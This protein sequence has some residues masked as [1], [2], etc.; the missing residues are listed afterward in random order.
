MWIGGF[1]GIPPFQSWRA[2]WASLD[3]DGMFAVYTN[4]TSRRPRVNFFVNC[5]E[6]AEGRDDKN[7]S[8]ND[9]PVLNVDKNR[10]FV[11]ATQGST[12]YF[13]AKTEEEKM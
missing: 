13:I 4:K 1:G 2:V 6:Y 9:W 7:G 3:E 10:C 11:V 8:F 5:L 12:Y